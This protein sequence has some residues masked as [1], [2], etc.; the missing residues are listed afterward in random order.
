MNEQY[1]YRATDKMSDL[2][3][4]NYSLLMVM[5]R[6]G[7]SL[8]FGDKS[9]KD[10]CEAQNVDYRTFLA[11]ANFISEE[12]YSYSA[13]DDSFSI[14]A[15]MD[16]LKRAHAYFLDFNLPAMRRKLIEAI[17]C[18]RDNDVAYLILK[19][20][21]EY[22]KEVRRHMEY[23]NE[24]VFTYVEQ[25]L[26]GKLSDK[27]N[28]ATFASKHNQIDTKLKELKNI[29]IKYYPEKENNN[30]LNAVLFDIFNCEQ[31]LASHCQVED[32]MFVPAVA[33]IEKR[34][35]DEQ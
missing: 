27:Y 20:F 29:I 18:S 11:V 24:A 34:L 5:S 17:D 6:F 9:V 14:P 23:E 22:A 19:F 32:Y 33:Q 21:D 7:L 3:C 4:D 1:K 25:L 28:I 16:Y 13:D 12:Q 15:L 2:I 10:V 30:L 35:K 8:G 31:D 26:Q